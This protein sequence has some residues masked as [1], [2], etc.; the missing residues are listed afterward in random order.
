MNEHDW[1]LAWHMHLRG[2][3]FTRL[4]QQ[5]GAGHGRIKLGFIKRGWLKVSGNGKSQPTVLRTTFD[6]DHS[7]QVVAQWLASRKRK[8]EYIS[9]VVGKPVDEVR[10][11]L[12]G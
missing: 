1:R 12:A 3:S 2:W 4:E 11:F 5:F 8:P 6:W 9:E 10:E 7:Q